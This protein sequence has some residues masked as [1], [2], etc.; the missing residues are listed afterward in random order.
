MSGAG[1]AT[2]VP[3]IVAM[4]TAAGAG[5]RAIVRLS[6]PDSRRLAVA[7]LAVADLPEPGIVGPATLDLGG[8]A[9][10]PLEVLTWRAP[11]SLTG[12]D[13]VEFHLPGWPPVVAE[14]LRRLV[15]AGARPAARGEF[16]RRGL[17]NGR[18][19]L[20][21]AL[22]VGR[23]AAARTAEEVHAAAAALGGASARNGRALR[24]AL[25][26]ALALVEAQLDFEDEDAEAVRPDELAA[27]LARA[28]ALARELAGRAR[29]SAPADGETDVVLLG[30]P[31]AGKSALLLALCPGART[32]VSSA[33]GT[34]RDAL[35]AR[36]LHGGRAFR[37][38][39]GPG[40][41]SDWPG[42][43][44]ADH[45]AMANY[46]AWLPEGAVV[47]HLTD[48]SA[49]PRAGGRAERLAAAGSRPVIEVASKVDLLADGG[50]TLGVLA[51]SSRTGA[52]LDALW[53]AIHAAAPAAPWP[54]AA[55][56]GESAAAEEVASLLASGDWQVRSGG[57]PLL[58]LGLR[59][60]LERL[61]RDGERPLAI[62]PEVL[63]RIF[64]RFCI[65]K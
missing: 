6:G 38:I 24:S 13:V 11:R 54:A 44:A 43:A 61:E 25:L 53:T 58:A 20:E 1:P 29:H 34:T 62:L 46:V 16:V 30:A 28:G 33:P 9:R 41:E 12:E 52:G 3:T 51:V 39:D 7:V 55:E 45:Q 27:A 10:L 50:V 49:D 65:G 40:V 14:I 31:N 47:L 64:S 48:V 21:G 2:T 42:L 35:E 23:L 15:V 8:G 4:A 17:A 63:D 22:A 60:A 26:D 18:L 57:L 36:V 5:A 59:D 32:T 56:L 37:L 19:D